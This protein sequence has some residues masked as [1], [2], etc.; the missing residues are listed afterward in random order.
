MKII[1]NFF[2][3][4]ITEGTHFGLKAAYGFMGDLTLKTISQG[5]SPLSDLAERLLVGES[6]ND[7]MPT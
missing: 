5:L 6:N 1:N 2:I 7:K 4:M 3:S